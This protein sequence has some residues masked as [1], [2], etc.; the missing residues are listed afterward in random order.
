M[1]RLDFIKM[2]SIAAGVCIASKEIVS[3]KETRL[4]ISG[5]FNCFR[6][7]S[8]RWGIHR[9]VALF[10]LLYALISTFSHIANIP[11][12]IPLAIAAEKNAAPPAADDATL[13]MPKRRW[14]VYLLPHSHV[15]I[16]YTAL[17]T[18]IEPKHWEYFEQAIEL[19][20]KTAAMPRGSRFKWNVEVLWAV[21]SYLKQA[22]P[23]KKRAFIDAVKRGWIGLDGLYCHELGG[24]C[25]DEE[26]VR[27]T[28]FAR[29]MRLE[30]GVEIDAAMATD[31]A[32]YTWGIV[33]VLAKSGIK[34]L[35]MGPNNSHRIGY[36]RLAWDN[37]PF[38]WQS[39]CGTCRVL[40]WQ[41]GNS[42]H[43]AF[44]SGPGFVKFLREFER[45]H[46]E[47][48]YE[49]IYFRQCRGDN[50]PPDEKL[51][52]WVSQWNS[53]HEYP[54]LI[55]A[56]TSELFRRFEQRYGKKIPTVRGDFTPYWEDGAASSAFETAMNRAAA[57]R[58][59]QAEILWS[60]L[61]PGE[62]AADRFREAW[63]NVLL[64]DEHTWGAQSY[65]QRGRYPPGSK[66]YK[67][68]WAIKRGFAVDADKQSRRLMDDALESRKAKSKTVAAMDVFNTC[69]W[70]RTDL[71]VVT[72]DT[73]VAGDVVR[74][75]QGRPLPSQRLANGDLAFLARDVP[76]LAAA[77]F[78]FHAG[79]AQQGKGKSTAAGK[80]LDNGLL[81]VAINEKTGAIASL[82][83][84]R[85]GFDLVDS[86]SGMGLNDY[87]YVP[88]CDPIDAVRNGRP[89][90]KIEDAG[91]LVAT[92]LVESDAPGCNKLTRRVRLI[93]GIE[94]VDITNVIEKKE[95]PLADLLKKNPTKEGFHIGFAFNVP[96]A[97]TRIET[98]WA[99]VRPEVDQ[100][101]GSC[102][103][104]FSVQC[105]V[106]VS[107]GGRGAT[108]A[109]IDTPIIEVGAIA[110][111]PKT[112]HSLEGWQK[113]ASPSSKIYAYVMN[114]YWTTNYQ[115]DQPGVKTFRY[116][117]SPHARYDAGR[118]AR[119][120]RE[121]SRPLLVVPVDPSAPPVRPLFEIDTD[122]VLATTI[123]PSMDG[124]A[125]IVRL[126]NPADTPE[127]AAIDWRRGERPDL[128]L[129]DFDEQ[130][131]KKVNGR[132]ELPP[133][134][135]VTLCAA[136]PK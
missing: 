1:R 63:R 84:S 104:W 117:I 81:R 106:D 12:L 38:Y 66:G 53:R 73:S 75:T 76:P 11:D 45:E 115:H 54:K 100:L 23:E 101:P 123:K 112:T 133:K 116:S 51:C 31:I 50:G 60:T 124:Q 98:P 55:I 59:T 5:P 119:F 8:A 64:Y 91:P 40:C 87:F 92:L 29:R 9:A 125:T 70:P 103:N 109:T 74:D 94:R 113:S 88:G 44:K 61:R 122:A 111:Q 48:P 130:K 24:L 18:E 102:K 68:Q 13:K 118:A 35:S 110:P 30:Y 99:V 72:K 136:H 105:F 10:V 14:E 56:T 69:S 128:F 127:S 107:G 28:D 57:E 114:N 93:D 86:K 89:T 33:P 17:Q 77:R 131:G 120:G 132:I 71:V 2:M 7:V 32:G 43:P 83:S 96:D 6:G 21:D 85:L 121:R 58:L 90:V 25:R 20:K 46:P 47:Y 41:C 4:M 135:I 15:D 78:T 80:T 37:R 126:F 67:E 22:T 65:A 52:D 134:G 16:G 49:M 108:L 27:L 34:Y 129:C 62:H 42:Y 97:Q 39:P 95:I 82:K 3:N 36:T 26:L 79:Q 19:S